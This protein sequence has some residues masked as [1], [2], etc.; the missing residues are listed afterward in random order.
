MTAD[1]RAW[2]HRIPPPPQE[3]ARSW[4]YATRRGDRITFS[5]STNIDRDLADLRADASEPIEILASCPGDGPTERMIVRY[6]APWSNPTGSYP[7]VWEAVA[8]T[9]VLAMIS[10]TSS[11]YDTARADLF[12]LLTTAVDNAGR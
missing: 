5:R 8:M 12:D 6:L 2:A 10:R 1:R 9:E 4:V 7:A 3:P 11:T